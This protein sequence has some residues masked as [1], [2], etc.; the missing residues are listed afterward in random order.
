MARSESFG[1]GLG[2]EVHARTDIINGKTWSLISNAAVRIGKDTFELSSY[3]GDYFVNLNKNPTLP[4]R[5][6]GKYLVSRS[7]HQVGLDHEVKYTIDLNNKNE[8]IHISLWKGMI[9]VRVDAE[10]EQT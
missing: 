4:M 8:K 9:S 6:E 10:L 1:S 3:D 5:L 2:L 7:I